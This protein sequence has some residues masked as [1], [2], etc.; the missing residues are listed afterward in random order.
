MTGLA[1]WRHKPWIAL[2]RAPLLAVV[3]ALLAAALIAVAQPRVAG[4]E[5]EWAGLAFSTTEPNELT[6]QVQVTAPDGLERAVAHY[7]VANPDGDIGGSVRAELPPGSQM[8]LSAT[9]ETIAANRFIPVGSVFTFW[10]EFETLDGQRIET[11]RQEFVFLDGRY[12]WDSIADEEEQITVYYYGGN[13]ERAEMALRATREA[14][15]EVEELLEVEVPY[16]VRVVVWRESREA[17]AAQRPRGAFSDHVITG[18]ARVAPDL[19]HVYDPLGDFVD[20][21]MHETAHIVT[22]VAGFG[23]FTRIPSWLDEGV[24]VWAQR[25]PGA[26]YERGVD[27]AIAQDNTIRLR[28]MTSGTNVP[29]QVNIFYGQSWHVVSFMLE[30]WGQESFA[31]LFR[32]IKSG[33]R[34]DDAMLQVYG[35]D[36]DGLYNLWREHVGLDP[37]E[38]EDRATA[39][40][41]PAAEATRP[42]LGLPSRPGRDDAGA[43]DPGGEIAPDQESDDTAVL[44]DDGGVS[45]TALI[46]LAVTLL[47]AGG[48]GGAGLWLLRG[49]R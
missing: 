7:S 25:R 35:F 32:V 49:N 4:A 13:R 8:D 28:T 19:I 31:E 16:P 42:P 48:L 34:T 9:L 24:A 26:G 44:G 27:Q 21:T 15:I 45:N 40:D 22:R 33:E 43:P 41:R 38:F 6:F 20:V 17:L 2:L 10:W 1:G 47:I 37:I 46:V 29:G 39:V 23:P 30:E 36:Q 5:P 18:G 12:D 14:M 11:E 3:V